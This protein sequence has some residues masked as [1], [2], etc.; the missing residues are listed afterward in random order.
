MARRHRNSSPAQAEVSG[1]RNDLSLPLPW[2]G[3]A[4]RDDGQGMGK[5]PTAEETVR[6]NTVMSW[7]GML[8]NSVR[9]RGQFKLCRGSRMRG[10]ETWV[11][12][13]GCE[14]KR[15][16]PNKRQCKRCRSAEEVWC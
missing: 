16:R 11:W 15:N 14:C 7:K 9:G 5:L 1:R 13:T 12:L 3:S 10:E 4:S 6:A 8:A 2:E